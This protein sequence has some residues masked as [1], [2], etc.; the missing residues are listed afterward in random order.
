[1]V[2]PA[3]GENIEMAGL[4]FHWVY[5]TPDCL[6]EEFEIQIS[7]SPTFDSVSGAKLD[8]GEDH[9][10]PPVGLLPATVY[11]WRMRGTVTAAPGP[12]SP[13]W[14]FYTGPACEA[15]Y[16]LA[17]EAIF[18]TGYMFTY[19]APSFQWTYP[20]GTCV[21]A[22]YHL[23]ASASEDFSS[24]LMDLNLDTPSKIAVPMIDL[25]NC[26]VYHW[27][28]AAK[29]GGTD[30]PYSALNSFSVNAGASCTQTCTEEQLIAPQPISPAHYANVG[31]SPTLELVPGLLQ[32]SYPMPCLPEGFGI[33]LSTTPDFSGPSLG[34]G[35]SPVTATGGSWTPTDLLEPATQ[36]WWEVF[37]GVG[38]TI[39]PSS[40][41]RSF[42]TGPVCEVAGDSLP[43]TLV[44]PLDGATVD[45]LHPDL[46]YTAG[47]GSCVPDGFAIYLGTDS[48]FDGEDA[49]SSFNFPFSTFI[50]DAL[51]DCTTYFWKVAPI[52]DGTG[53]TASEVRSFT[54]RTGTSCPISGHLNGRA[55]RDAACRYGPGLGWDILGYFVA[56]EQSPI[57][58]KDI[59]GDWYAADNP[60][61]PGERC[62]VPRDDIEL[63]G[64]GGNLR[65]LNPPVA[66][67]SSL[68]EADCR[69]AGGKWITPSSPLGA[70][71]TSY[72]ECP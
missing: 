4:T 67:K 23:Q 9:W 52:L 59:S 26:G 3:D 68:D 18:P 19:D 55:I 21:P 66:C 48:D 65:I 31:T 45:T 61:N 69:E 54:V 70:V 51:D 17:P 22:G 28:V 60:D 39:G 34:G 20:D 50:P 35:V 64:D 5:N 37:A 42:F 41:R 56:G 15:A 10:S 32:W 71:P 63:L 30:G 53:L 43:P 25:E 14:I 33:H 49:Y 24:L 11:Y 44:K 72:C 29:A 57:A 58:G 16:L 62:W 47:T 8:V 13:T 7:Q 2:A 12:W 1:M 6:P 27:R 46:H 38:T 40:P 36:Y